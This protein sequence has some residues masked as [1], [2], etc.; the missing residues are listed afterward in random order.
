VTLFNDDEPDLLRR[1][2]EGDRAAL[3]A[4]YQAYVNTVTRSVVGALRRYGGTGRQSWRTIAGE[5]PDLVQDVFTRAFEPR[6]RRRFDG[7]REYGPYLGQ[8][9]RNVVV[10]HL[11][12][13][14]R[15]VAAERDMVLEE[16]TLAPAAEPAS[17]GAGADL[18]TMT[19][20][21]RYVAGLP[22]DLRRVHEALYVR[23]LSQRDAA[24]V[25]GLGRQVV[26][27]MEAKLRDGLRDA[28]ATIARGS[29]SPSKSAILVGRP[30]ARAAA[31]TSVA[32][33][34]EKTGSPT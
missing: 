25:L 15:Q 8:I 7:L 13:Q 24:L 9:T 27:T 20:V 1:F 22:P 11:R 6:T 30:A 34:T 31:T 32:G 12:K 4:V 26:R 3:D 10:D 33:E 21:R 23:G 16:I 14:S 5:V 19:L 18:R 17:P 28:L 29:E 2:R